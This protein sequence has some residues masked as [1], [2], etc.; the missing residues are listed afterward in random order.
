L[1]AAV[2]AQRHGRTA[3]FESVS[4][5][6]RGWA[7]R[8]AIE[9][10]NPARVAELPMWREILETADPLLSERALDPALDTA[11]TA[12]HLSLT[13]P[14]ALTGPLLTQVPALYHGRINDVLLTGFALALA[15]WRQRQGRGNA[16]AVLFELEG[17]GREDI[18]AGVDLS[19]TVGWFTSLFPV[20][21]DP[22]AI[23]QA[24]AGPRLGQA[25]KRVKEQLRALPDN[26]LGYGL[27]RFMNPET[28]PQL[29]EYSSPQIGFN[30]LGRMAAPDLQAGGLVSGALGG[31]G[32]TEMSLAHGIELNALTLDRS[33]GSE[34][35]ANWSWAGNLFTEAQILD[36]AQDWFRVLEK[37]VAHAADPQAGGFTPSD[38]TLVSLDQAQIEQLEDFYASDN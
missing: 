3:V 21:L 8:L 11:R 24:L 31:G 7:E 6:F 34:L 22:G 28:A 35:L 32:D 15:G 38:L 36:L 12:R 20:R 5:S 9:A 23:D 4:T 13:L 16:T 27:L 14:S 25:L 37:L 29:K 19:R 10:R 2:E 26:G 1:E 33:A 18:F 17:H 30:Y